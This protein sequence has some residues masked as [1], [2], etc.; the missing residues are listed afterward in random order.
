MDEKNL[1]YFK[2]QLEAIKAE[3]NSDV[4]QTLSEM[5]TQTGNVPDPNDRASMESD[6]SFELRIRGR[7]RKLMDKVDE[8]LARIEDGSYGICVGC[9]CEI[10]FKRLQA[11]PVAKFCIDCKTRQE[12][13]EKEQGR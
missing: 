11:R 5:T 10:A 8:A 9:G 7:E 12:Q 2:Q 13:Q 4:E 1:Q 6:R 3:I